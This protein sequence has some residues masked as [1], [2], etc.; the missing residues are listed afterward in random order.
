LNELLTKEQERV[1]LYAVVLDASSPYFV[2][3]IEKYMC[4]L[5]LIDDTVNPNEAKG[6]IPPYISLTCFSRNKADL[7]V[8][9]RMGYVIRIHRGDT[10]KFSKS[11]QLNCDMGIK[12]AWILFDPS[13]GS[14]PVK[15]S[16]RT[17][18]F[19]EDDKKRVKEIRRFGDKFFKDNDATEFAS[20]GANV[21]EVDLMAMVMSRESSKKGYDKLTVFDGEEFI[22]LDIEKPR[23]AHI[24]NQD[25]VRIRGIMQK[26]NEFLV[27]DYSNVIRIDKD[28]SAAKELKKKVEKAKKDKKYSE[29]LDT[30][31]PT[32]DQS[33]TVSEILAKKTMSIS[34]K[35]LFGLEASKIKGQK[36]SVS[37]N[38]VEI[39]PKD[40]KG[41][42]ISVDSKSRKQYD[43][44]DDIEN[45]Y[46]LQLFT[47]DAN[48]PDDHSV[49]TL[50]LCTIDGRGKEFFPD[51]DDKGTPS[52]LKKIYKTITK[53]WFVLNLAL[54]PVVSEGKSVFFIVD[55]KLTL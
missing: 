17:Y 13:E 11:F 29:K 22:K 41:C 33:K 5:K 6:K 38:V 48:N 16:G 19:V 18:T 2:K 26:K 1:N 12:G 15:F 4:V 24:L 52:E 43:L 50:Y 7:P 32:A 53:P 20:I 25:I 9:D 54:E 49:Y 34:L 51:P 45:Y 55:T 14:T 10:K 39:G 31:M 27:N 28:H 35:E 42:I 21:D 23:F 36:Y 8:I 40:P 47:K 3:E 37:V 30:Y 46:R 44:S